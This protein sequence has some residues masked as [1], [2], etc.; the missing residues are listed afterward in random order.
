MLA[1]VFML[2]KSAERGWCR[3]KGAERLAELIAGV[4]FK[5]G[6]PENKKEIAA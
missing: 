3:L 6:V 4:Q 2:A 1:M 5:N